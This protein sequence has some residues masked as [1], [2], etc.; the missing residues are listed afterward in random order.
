[1]YLH[2]DGQAGHELDQFASCGVHVKWHC[3]WRKVIFVKRARSEILI[4]SCLYDLISA[5]GSGIPLGIHSGVDLA[6]PVNGSKKTTYDV[7]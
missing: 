3:C 6:S 7:R 1:M 2:N 5:N 4:Q